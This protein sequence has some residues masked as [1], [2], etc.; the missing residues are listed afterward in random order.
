MHI[1]TATFGGVVSLL[2]FRRHVETGVPLIDDPQIWTYSAEDM[3][4]AAADAEEIKQADHLYFSKLT[5]STHQ[6]A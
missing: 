2:F 3:D 4:L 6:Q 1:R 5:E